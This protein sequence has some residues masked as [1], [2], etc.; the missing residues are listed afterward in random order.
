MIRKLG[1]FLSLCF[2]MV[3]LSG[4][5]MSAAAAGTVTL[6]PATYNFGTVPHGGYSGWAVFTLKNAGTSTVSVSGV[7]VSG[8]FVLYSAY[9]GSS[10]GAGSSCPLYV[11]FAPTAVGAATGNLTATDGAGTQTSVLSGTGS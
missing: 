1:S 11:Y 9:C 8:P 7:T 6:S 10:L 4:G 2:A 3:L 5:L